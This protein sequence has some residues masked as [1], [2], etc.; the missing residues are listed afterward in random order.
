V[1]DVNN[2]KGEAQASKDRNVRFLH[3]NVTLRKTWEQ[4]LALAQREFDRLDIVINNAG[5]QIQLSIQR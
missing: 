3:G 5:E 2:E 4:A 1:V